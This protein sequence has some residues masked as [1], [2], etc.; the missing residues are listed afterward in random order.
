MKAGCGLGNRPLHRWC[1]LSLGSSVSTE[2]FEAGIS[3]W[4]GGGTAKKKKT[5]LEDEALGHP[6]GHSEIRML[7]LSACFGFTLKWPG[8]QPAPSP[9]LALLSSLGLQDALLWFSFT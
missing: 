9:F 1:R 4:N 2:A 5:I 6:S 8:I 7:N 3:D